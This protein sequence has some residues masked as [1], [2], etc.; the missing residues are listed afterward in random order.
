MESRM[1]LYKLTQSVNNGYDTYDSVVVAA[2]SAKAAR[3]IHPAKENWDG[4]NDEWGDWCDVEDV[5]VE[6]IGTA[7]LKTG[8]VLASFNAG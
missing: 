8:V 6:E 2:R 4:T 7:K 1:K 3:M 5:V